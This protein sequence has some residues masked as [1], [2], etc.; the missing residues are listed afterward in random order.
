[1]ERG[2]ALKCHAVNPGDADYHCTNPLRWSYLGC[3]RNVLIL[4]SGIS[5]DHLLISGSAGDD[6]NANDDPATRLAA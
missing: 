4:T 1:M 5:Q 3:R 6:V 2:A